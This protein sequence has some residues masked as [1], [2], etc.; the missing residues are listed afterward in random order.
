MSALTGSRI[1]PMAT[2]T[3][4][5]LQMPAQQAEIIVNGK[6]FGRGGNGW[7]TNGSSEEAGVL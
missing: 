6:K 5:P 4:V 3:K 7:Y 1:T 2:S